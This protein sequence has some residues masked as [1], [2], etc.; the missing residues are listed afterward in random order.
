MSAAQVLQRAR[1]LGIVLSG[2]GGK[3]RYEAPTGCPTL[4][5]RQALT[6][7]KVAILKLLE[8]ERM[9]TGMRTGP[10][11]SDFRAALML[12]RLHVCC[13]CAL[14]NFAPDPAGLGRCRHFGVEA[15]PF[16]PFWCSAFVASRRET[17]T[18]PPKANGEHPYRRHR[19]GTFE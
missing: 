11:P 2:D 12:G 8:V 19:T 15:W 18:T 9:T 7:H 10:R 6:L 13:N 5:L 14:F 1:A 16:V 4:E 17:F 3:L